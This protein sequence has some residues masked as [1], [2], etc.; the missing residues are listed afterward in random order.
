MELR[1]RKK[2]PDYEGIPDDGGYMSLFY[3]SKLNLGLTRPEVDALWQEYL[4]N[5]RRGKE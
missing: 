5:E 1:R 2:D 4:I 3:K